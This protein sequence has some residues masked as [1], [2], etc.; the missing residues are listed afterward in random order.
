MS[1]RLSPAQRRSAAIERERR[2]VGYRCL[3]GSWGFANPIA[4][5]RDKAEH[6]AAYYAWAARRTDRPVDP[7]TGRRGGCLVD[8]FPGAAE[9][10]RAMN[11]AA[12]KA[13]FRIARTMPKRRL[14]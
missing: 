11:I 6:R 1:R 3:S 8:H 10:G 7:C 5:E 14:P 2:F 13:A 9:I 12:A 4:H